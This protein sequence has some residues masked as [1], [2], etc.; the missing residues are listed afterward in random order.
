MFFARE[1]TYGFRKRFIFVKELIN[2]AKPARVLDFGCGT[3]QNLTIPLAACFPEVKF[4]GV[5]SDVTTIGFART[6]NQ[7]LNL[8]FGMPN[9]IE[10][11][12]PFDLIIASE[13]I[14]HVEEP[15]ELLAYLHTHL[16][17]QGKIII[18]LPNGYGPFEAAALLD[19]IFHFTGIKSILRGIKHRLFGKPNATQDMGGTLAISPHVNFFTYAG[20]SRLIEQ[21]GLHIATSR[22]RTFLCGFLFDQVLKGQAI[23][24]WNASIADSLPYF[25]TSDWMFVL[26][27][28]RTHFDSS[29]R[30]QRGIDARFRR[31]LF[32][33][34]WGR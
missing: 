27:K 33:K 12:S 19:A 7:Q 5:D 24:Q 26:D 11:D 2:H 25:L 21:N 17:E 15:G 16:S 14:E 18:T 8:N 1:S 13:V 31:Y 3:G 34:R 4:I 10:S 9:E 20:I 28:G 22:S 30:Y 29:A 23:I 6:Q 32:A